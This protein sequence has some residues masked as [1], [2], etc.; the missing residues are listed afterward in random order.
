MLTRTETGEEGTDGG[1][2]LYVSKHMKL[3]LT[4]KNY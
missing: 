2:E 3:H 1:A 4:I